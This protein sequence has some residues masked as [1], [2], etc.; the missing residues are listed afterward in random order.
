MHPY[1]DYCQ[2]V[3][4]LAGVIRARSVLAERRTGGEAAR[5][6]G[7]PALA[8]R[9]AGGAHAL[10]VLS[11]PVASDAAGNLGFGKHRRERMRSYTDLLAAAPTRP[12]T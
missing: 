8:R 12:Q 6:P 9:H 1:P 5:V 10:R 11:S 2:R 7:H 4:T 3:P